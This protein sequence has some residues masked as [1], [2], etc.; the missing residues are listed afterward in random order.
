MLLLPFLTTPSLS[1]A[2]PFASRATFMQY[3]NETQ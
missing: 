1:G 2:A 3:M